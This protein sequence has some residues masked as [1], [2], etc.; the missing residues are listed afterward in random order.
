[1]SPILCYHHLLSP[2]VS[3]YKKAIHFEPLFLICRPC[4]E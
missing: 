1:M 3:L 4:Y 2:L